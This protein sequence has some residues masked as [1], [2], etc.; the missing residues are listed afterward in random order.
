MV[1]EDLTARVA[2]LQQQVLSTSA[3]RPVV[4]RLQLAKGGQKSVDDVIDNIRSNVSVEPVPDL[5]TIG[6]TAVKKKPGQEVRCPA[7]T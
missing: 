4:E 5:S 2:T 6:P 3:L 1:T 7:F